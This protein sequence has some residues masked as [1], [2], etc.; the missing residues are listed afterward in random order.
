[1]FEPKADASDT[2][3]RILENAKFLKEGVRAEVG[4]GKKTLFWYHNWM[5]VAFSLQVYCPTNTTP[6]TR[7]YCCENVG[8]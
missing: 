4:N 3:R 5:D 8:Y 6:H 7:S 1:M 2:W